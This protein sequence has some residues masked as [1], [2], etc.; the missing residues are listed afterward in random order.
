MSWAE[1]EAII[2][3]PS[4]ER[5]QSRIIWWSAL[6]FS[7][8]EHQSSAFVLPLM[9][10]AFHNNS[11]SDRDKGRWH[12]DKRKKPWEWM[13]CQFNC[14]YCMSTP[15][16]SCNVSQRHCLGVSNWLSSRHQ[17]ERQLVKKTGIQL[18]ERDKIYSIMLPHTW[19]YFRTNK[20]KTPSK[21]RTLNMWNRKTSP[22]SESRHVSQRAILYHPISFWILLS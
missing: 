21:Y 14:T 12:K 3:P 16:D 5:L 19:K 8:K 9:M 17:K 6:T 22:L 7:H 13:K 2:L 18:R 20:Q 11:N 10:T 1:G 15:D 4:C